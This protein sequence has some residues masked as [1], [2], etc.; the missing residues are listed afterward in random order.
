MSRSV[1]VRCF[2]KINTSLRVLGRRPDGYHELDTVFVTL[3]LR[4]DLEIRSSEGGFALEAPGAPAETGPV[5]DNLVLRAAR[6]LQAEV[7][8]ER[9]PGASFRLVKN[10]PVAAGLGGGSSDAA[11]A[12]EGLDR[13]FDLG[14]PK[15]VLAEIA[16]GIGSDVPYFLEGGWQRGRGRGEILE[17]LPPRPD[18]GVVLLKPRLPLS[19][20]AVFRDHAAWSAAHPGE[21]PLGRLPAAASDPAWLAEAGIELRDDLTDAALRLAPILADVAERAARA[22]PGAALGMT[23]SGPTL[24][25]LLPPGAGAGEAPASL[26]E[27]ADAWRTRTMG[28]AEYR[29][30]RFA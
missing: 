3:D 26:L 11:G 5:E 28:R 16:L 21:R 8:R 7:G 1:L 20:A 9:L 15:P 19:T 18:L 14:V 17:S 13:L 24:F 4:D 29:D 10:V 22:F 27:V 6:A 30:R 2:A 25:L 12:L 23:G